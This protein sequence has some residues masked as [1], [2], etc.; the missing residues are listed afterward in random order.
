VPFTRVVQ[1]DD[2]AVLAEILKRSR[3]FMAPT[4]PYRD[5][6]FY[7]VEG[8]LQI[9]GVALAEHQAGIRL[10]HVILDDDGAV[11]GRATLNEIV[12]GPLQS[13]SLGYFV[14]ER[15]NGRGFASRA[16][17][18]MV[19]IAFGEL[20]LHRVQA[21]TQLE[22]LASQRV[23]AKNGFL[24]YGYAPGY[25]LLAGQ[26]RDELL[27]QRLATDRGDGQAADYPSSAI[28]RP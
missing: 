26:W 5:E 21:G 7:T 4:A 20:G 19:S 24:Q 27:F 23:L 1:R 6:S 3:E 10:P 12:R 16:T 8:Q 22:N 17:A 13:A 2:A 28:T 15:R 18:E 11:V 25:L 14:D 9:I